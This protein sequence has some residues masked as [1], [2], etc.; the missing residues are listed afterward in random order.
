MTFKDALRT[1]SVG[2]ITKVALPSF[3]MR[4]SSSLRKIDL[5][6]DELRV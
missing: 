4:L 5:A 3:F 6:F 2:T 1:V